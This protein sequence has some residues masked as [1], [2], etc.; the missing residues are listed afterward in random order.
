MKCST[1]TTN[2]IVEESDEP[3]NRIQHMAS[4]YY[5]VMCSPVPPVHVYRFLF[6]NKAEEKRNNS[7]GAPDSADDV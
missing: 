6:W 2:R 4:Y 1:V 7:N 3:P 5:P